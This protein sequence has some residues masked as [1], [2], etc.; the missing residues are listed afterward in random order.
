[1]TF[2][3][4][5]LESFKDLPEEVLSQIRIMAK[6]IKDFLWVN[7]KRP[8]NLGIIEAETRSMPIIR[9]FSIILDP[10]KNPGCEAIYQT[11]KITFF[12]ERLRSL[13]LSDIEELLVHEVIH[14]VQHY[15]TEGPSYKKVVQDILANK[16][17]D[18]TPYHL[19]PTEFEAHLG[20]IRFQLFN[21]LKNIK[22]TTLEVQRSDSAWGRQKTMLLKELEQFIRQPLKETLSN[23]F[24]LPAWVKTNVKFLESLVKSPQ[25]LKTFKNR[26]FQVWQ[27]LSKFE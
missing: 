15:Q 26:L 22:K 16:S 9:K 11:T 20:A 2:Q 8:K 7:F 27:E 12:Q 4:F 24:S 5:F 17:P 1:M 14:G 6:R 10:K 3:D 23:G 18:L 19:D 13:S 21:R 25:H